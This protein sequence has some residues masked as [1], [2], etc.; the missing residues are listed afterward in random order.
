M[1]TPTI[2]NIN[3]GVYAIIFALGIVGHSCSLLTFCQRELRSTSTTVLFLGT[4][5]SDLL[6][7]FIRLDDFLPINL[8]TSQQSASYVQICQF[9]TFLVSL[10]QTTS[11]WLI[12]CVSF[13][14]LIRARLPH[15]TRRWCTKRNAIITL[16]LIILSSVALNS[17][18]LL[19]TFAPRLGATRFVCGLPRDYSTRYIFFYYYVWTALQ[20]CMNILLPTLL[21]V[22]CLIGIYYSVLH[23]ATVRHSS[24]IQRH[25]L[26]LTLS[27]TLLFLICTLPYGLTRMIL[28]YSVD[29]TELEK[30]ANFILATTIVNMLLGTNY[31][32][33]FYVHCLTSTLFR[34]TFVHTAKSCLRRARR[35]PNVIQPVVHL[36]VSVRPTT[37][38]ALGQTSRVSCSQRR[39][40]G[41]TG[42]EEQADISSVF[43]STVMSSKQ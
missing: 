17:H 40:S 11:A 29:A 18:V 12:V 1:S 33:A 10:A 21:M 4:T 28:N 36:T 2:Q 24:Q 35:Q 26:L 38:D 3:T 42:K 8:G 15:R 39:M 23:A 31:S 19:P 43:V 41:E 14:R 6:F 32:L 13:D 5:L 25:M 20:I 16:A 34:Q 30:D 9:H 22:A 27:K 37:Q 7:L